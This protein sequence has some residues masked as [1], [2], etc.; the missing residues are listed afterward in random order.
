LNKHATANEEFIMTDTP[1]INRET[2]ALLVMDFQTTIVENFATDSTALLGRTSA[3]LNAARG[4][5]L[6][7][8]YV[9][10]GFRPGYPEVSSRNLLFNVLRQSGFS[11]GSEGTE[12]HAAVTPKTGE[13][14]VTKHRVGAFHGTDLDMFLRARDIDTLILAGITTSGV[15]LSTLRHA[16]DADYRLIVAGDCCS[17]GDDEVHRVLLEKVFPK[18]ATV[19]TATQIIQALATQR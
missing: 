15:V 10:V 13:P 18:Q 8:I 5:G 6:L 17:D 9:V 3:L 16:A 19:S 11:A 12:T 1:S 4:V 14:V 2:A 7:V